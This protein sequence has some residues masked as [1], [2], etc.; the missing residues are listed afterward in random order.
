MK[1]KKSQ[2]RRII[3]EEI[4]RLDEIPTYIKR[5]AAARGIPHMGSGPRP[6]QAE[7]P[8]EDFSDDYESEGEEHD[9]G[10]IDG[11]L[12]SPRGT[13]TVDYDIGYERGGFQR[14]SDD[15]KGVDRDPEDILGGHSV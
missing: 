5:A 12:R 3:K 9:R 10:F 11:Y 1:I 2:L 7:V 8:S 14:D 6:K 13:M 15:E 4:Q